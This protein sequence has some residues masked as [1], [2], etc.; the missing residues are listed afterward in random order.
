MKKGS[1]AKLLPLK[2]YLIQKAAL[3]HRENSPQGPDLGFA[4]VEGCL[5]KSINGL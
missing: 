4:T 1:T 2:D 5:D 3:P